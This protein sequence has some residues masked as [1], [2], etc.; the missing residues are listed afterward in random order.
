MDLAAVVHESA[1]RQTAAGFLA[2]HDAKRSWLV[3]MRALSPN[4][5]VLLCI[6]VIS[7]ITYSGVAKGFGAESVP[8]SCARAASA[9][10]VFV[11]LAALAPKM[12]ARVL[13]NLIKR[14]RCS[15]IHMPRELRW[16]PLV[17]AGWCI[18]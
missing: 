18:L 17:F 13:R 1:E 7:F 3:M 5:E 4:I 12:D 15:L 2:V 8:A 16:I 6:A 14:P 11:L 9:A 10:C